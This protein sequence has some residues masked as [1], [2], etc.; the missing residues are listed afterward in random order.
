[1]N[2]NKPQRASNQGTKT[3]FQSPGLPAEIPPSAG[4]SFKP[5]HAVDIEQSAGE[6]AWFEVHP[7]NYMVE[8]GPRLAQ[9]EALRAEY[10][11]SLH[12]VSMSL[13][14]GELPDDHHLERL[15]KL[16]DHFQPGRVSEHL[17]WSSHDGLYLADLLPAAL[18][19][20]VLE[21]VI[22][23]IDKTQ[24]T[25]GR[26]ILIENPSSY[27]PR[28]DSWLSELQFLVEVA[29]RSGCGLLMDVNN[30]FVSAHNLGFDAADYIDAIPHDL[31]GEIHLAGHSIDRNDSDPILIDSHCSPVSDEVWA[32]YQ[33]LINRIGP[34][35]TL[36]EWDTDIPQW[37]E[38]RDQAHK[39]ND[40]LRQA[41]P[42]EKRAS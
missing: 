17:A 4:T 26:E 11:L 23:A 14:A 18:T 34:Q 2:F 15:R 10:P 9:L 13:G 22:N 5:Q 42:L 36:I 29:K 8:G 6:V 32:L 19:T 39:A 27:L 40:Y 35:P 41:Q 33:R 12:G 3:I 24:T 25:L 30:V 1:M 21:G 28:P 38:L 31:V 16:V 20:E 37:A 7:E